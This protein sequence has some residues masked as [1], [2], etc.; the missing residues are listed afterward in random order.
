[1]CVRKPLSLVHGARWQVKV[2]DPRCG[3]GAER[4]HV[5]GRRQLA[6]RV[7]AAWRQR[8]RGGAREQRHGGIARREASAQVEPPSFYAAGCPS[9]F[10]CLRHRRPLRPVSAAIVEDP[11]APVPR[12]KPPPPTKKPRATPTRDAKFAKRSDPTAHS[13]VLQH[14]REIFLQHLKAAC[15]GP[16]QGFEAVTGKRVLNLGSRSGRA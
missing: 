13:L 8:V 11:S 14:H 6:L 9:P 12:P 1:M 2:Q 10:H 15:T 5:R 3:L 4:R 16:P 7:A